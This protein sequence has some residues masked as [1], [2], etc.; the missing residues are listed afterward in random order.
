MNV[1][2]VPPVYS[3]I[4]SASDSEVAHETSSSGDQSVLNSPIATTTLPTFKLI[5]DNVDIS[6]HPRVETSQ[7]HTESFHY[8]H[9][10][11]VR[12]R[13]DFSCFSETHPFC[14]M[15]SI[16]VN[17]ILPKENNLKML[18][19]NVSILVAGCACR[20]MPFFRKMVT[21][22]SVPRHI[23]HKYSYQMSK[24]SNVVS[25]VLNLFI[26]LHTYVLCIIVDSFGC[27]AKK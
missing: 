19:S 11:V 9:V 18:K 3:P 7:H 24:T 22:S 1:S 14:S 25:T 8:S 23:H 16:D 2:P 21:P 6:I 15:P 12:D 13:I 4:E 20:H 10:Y 26:Q 27:D 17:L 5:G